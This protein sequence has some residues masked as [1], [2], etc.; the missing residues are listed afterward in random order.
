MTQFN[1][2][3]AGVSA[4]EIDIS[5]PAARRPSGTPAAVIGT[6]SKGP[7]FVP[8]TL[9]TLS[10]FSAKFG[11]SDGEK[12]GPLA[13]KHWL[14][15]ANALTYLRVLGAGDCQ[16]RDADGNVNSAGFIVGDQ[17]PTPSGDYGDNPYANEEGENG[18]VYFL[19]AFMSESLGS[20]VFSSAGLQG[21][22]GIT[23]GND[24]AVPV[25]RGVLM[26]ASGVIASLSSSFG[27]GN[28]NAPDS[29]F[30]ANSATA[31]GG[32]VG[33]VRLE[34]GRQEFVLFLSGHKGE[35]PK[36]PNVI[37]SS[38]D[39]TSNGYFG[40]V[41]NRDPS[42]LQ[43]AGHCLYSHWD[44]HP[45]V[46]VVTGSGLVGPDF[47]A[48]ATLNVDAAGF[49]PSAFLTMSDLARN[50][51]S[52]T[53]PNYE[54]WEDRFSSAV[55]PWVISQKFGGS[56][57][58][59]F[60]LHALDAGSS[61]STNYKISIENI[62]PSK[63]GDFGAFDLVLRDWND[64]DTL[65]KP[66]EQW[67]ALSLDP[68]S[69]RYIAKVI[70]DATAFFDFDRPEKSQ[71]LVIEGNYSLRSNYVRVEVNPALEDGFIEPT[72]LPFGFRGITHLV[73]SGSAPLYSNDHGTTLAD[74]DILKRALTPPLPMRRDIAVKTGDQ[75]RVDPNLYWGVKFEHDLTVADPNASI[76]KNDSIK[77]FAKFFPG[78]ATT[79]ANFAIGDNTG[80]PDTPELGIIDAD[81]FCRNLFT[82]ENIKVVTG[83]SGLADDS[84]WSQAEYVRA[85]SIPVDDAN[86]TRGLITDDLT[87]QRNRRHCKFSF[88]LQGGFDG[89]NVFNNDMSNLTN[90]SVIDD[91]DYQSRGRE[92]GSTVRAYAKA[93]EIMRN[94]VNTDIQLL[95]IP[96]IRHPY[97]TDMASDAVRDRF[98]AMYV[99]DVE[100]I[101]G[102]KED[103]EKSGGP[104]SVSMTSQHFSERQIDNSFAAAYF[105]DVVI[106]DP[107]TGYSVVSPPSVAVLGALALNDAIGN[108]WNAPAGL[109]RGS[110]PSVRAA[111][112][113]LHK[114]NMDALYDV[115]INPIVALT[116][117]SGVVVWGQKTLQASPSALDRI[118]VRRLLIMIRREVRD[119]AQRIIFEQNREATLLA[120]SSAVSPRL[121]R[122]QALAGLEQFKVVIDS[123][124]TTA[125]DVENGVIRGKIFV[126]PTKSIEY[127]SLDF[128]VGNNVQDL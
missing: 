6:A 78:H 29:T 12:F 45:S 61:V 99:M 43:E 83:S 47:G 38:F 97:I 37:A 98:D 118:N 48:E 112:V 108:P 69:D 35:N 82:L 70:G 8:L 126:R 7:A 54:N 93:V 53:V 71:K 81:R 65:V 66:V 88:F 24:T 74:A 20:A 1:Q 113:L 56:H 127:V 110:L 23:P 11:M 80:A 49:E 44:L 58:N 116:P 124:T 85:G 30:V 62:V 10:D 55:S 91:M 100:Q 50:V 121:K 33:S 72:A 41:L 104:I 102:N 36:Y 119:I 31:P 57:Q 76:D 67:R 60:R 117:D 86:K 77:S 120:F 39:M 79:N 3:S 59:L 13:A 52:S 111:N 125:Q 21:P 26:T 114:E 46:A 95:A 128:V 17:L 19:G 15:N 123:T 92:N 9:G 90:R 4:T 34:G 96:G 89:T 5:G 109:L 68:S 32:P 28:N 84:V 103:I 122:I 87:L 105:P 73:T 63:V 106:N 115:N 16:K 101:D 25:I 40:N 51:G 27:G 107:D 75:R 94:V 14:R 22:D 64:R 42:K 2:G 18:R